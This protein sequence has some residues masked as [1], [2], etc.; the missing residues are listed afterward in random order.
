MSP[1]GDL[2][3]F[4]PFGP[5][6]GRDDVPVVVCGG[7]IAVVAGGGAVAVGVDVVSTVVGAVVVDVTVGMVSDVVDVDAPPPHPAISATP[8]ASAETDPKRALPFIKT[9]DPPEVGSPR[10]FR[11]SWRGPHCA[12][13][14]ECCH[15]V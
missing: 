4:E 10:A 6:T 3:G 9:T 11:R 7:A 8:A 13:P 15:S 2:N 5:A 14:R 12:V 1:S